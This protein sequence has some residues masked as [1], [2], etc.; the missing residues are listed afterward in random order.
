MKEITNTNTYTYILAPVRKVTDQQR[1]LILKHANSKREEGEM[2][3][4]PMLDAPQEDKTGYNIVMRELK[5]LNIMSTKNNRVDIG[6]DYA[7]PSEGS[8]VDAGIAIA[9][10]LRLNLVKELLFNINQQS[11][12]QFT[13]E[14]IKEIVEEN[15]QNSARKNMIYKRLDELKKSKE[16]VID[17]DV[18]MKSEAQEWQRI[19]LGLALGVL[20]KNPDFKIRMGNLIGEDDPNKKTYPKVIKEIE[21]RQSMGE[22]L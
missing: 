8:M 4:D 1:E 19:N 16:L 20:A 12:H 6:W 9:L 21:R 15:N 18:E 2:V 10:G 11:W 13:I 3:F 7:T 5:F 14:A 22:A 17:W